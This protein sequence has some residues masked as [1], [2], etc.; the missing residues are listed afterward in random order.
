MGLFVVLGTIR[1]RAP[2]TKEEVGF[3]EIKHTMEQQEKKER[4]IPNS[5]R[6]ARSFIKG[7]KGQEKARF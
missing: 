6:A 3:Q 5:G 7:Q 2:T 1:A 4:I